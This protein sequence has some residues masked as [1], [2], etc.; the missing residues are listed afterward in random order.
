MWL[1]L[2]SEEKGNSPGS[3]RNSFDDGLHRIRRIKLY[4]ASKLQAV[5][6]G[7]DEVETSG[8]NV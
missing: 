2:T 1:K 8:K 7:H 3:Y 6:V 5:D 4:E